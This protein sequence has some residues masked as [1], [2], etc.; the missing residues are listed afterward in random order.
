LDN[1]VLPT[2][3]EGSSSLLDIP[4]RRVLSSQG[5]L[6]RV[7]E[8]RKFNFSEK[9]QEAFSMNIYTLGVIFAHHNFRTTFPQEL[10][11]YP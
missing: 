7:S 2:P 3:K 10:W 6:T 8:A 4:S 11:L 1:K 5:M 9:H